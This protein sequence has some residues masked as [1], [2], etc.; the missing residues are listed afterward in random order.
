MINWFVNE[1]HV[2][3]VWRERAKLQ[4][5]PRSRKGEPI[6]LLAPP[7][8]QSWVDLVNAVLV[9]IVSNHHLIWEGPRCALKVK[10]R[11]FPFLQ[12]SMADLGEVD[13]LSWGGSNEVFNM[14]QL[15]KRNL[16]PS[17][18]S[19]QLASEL[20]SQG[21]LYLYGMILWKTLALPTSEPCTQPTVTLKSEN[22][23]TTTIGILSDPT[24]SALDLE[25]IQLCLTK[26]LS[27]K[28]R[29]CHVI[30]PSAEIQQQVL[31]IV[32]EERI[33][34]SSSVIPAVAALENHGH[35][36]FSAFSNVLNGAIFPCKSQHSR[37]S[38]SVLEYLRQSNARNEG[39]L[40]LEYLPS[41]CW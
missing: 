12:T 3:R 26:L 22:A 10:A 30:V 38:L 40:P 39:V 34:C 15:E 37:L 11:S 36:A 2:E 31:A 13:T 17:M 21:D 24:V 35:E 25:R 19:K 4:S 16:I 1:S 6:R 18:P 20:F 33:A 5:A 23:S 27:I 29:P 8:C 7:R 9:A 14:E 28:N 41:C 32:R